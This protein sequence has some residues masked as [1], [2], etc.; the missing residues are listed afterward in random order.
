MWGI[1]ERPRASP[2]GYESSRGF[3]RAR[4]RSPKAKPEGEARRRSPKAKPE[5]EARRRSPKAKPEGKAPPK[6]RPILLTPLKRPTP[7]NTEN[8]A[9]RTPSGGGTARNTTDERR[10]G[11]ADCTSRASSSS[12][13][14]QSPAGESNPPKAPAPGTFQNRAEVPGGQTDTKRRR[15]TKSPV[16]GPNETQSPSTHRRP[17]KTQTKEGDRPPDQT[18]PPDPQRRPTDPPESALTSN[19]RSISGLEVDGAAE[20]GA[21]RR[22]RRRPRRQ[23]AVSATAR[24]CPLLQTRPHPPPRPRAAASTASSGSAHLQSASSWRIFRKFR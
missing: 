9:Q 15:E 10:E 11:T 21:L 6:S 7:T 23:P 20:F 14:S 5:G 16:S 1:R 3:G 17:E 22:L 19:C 4:R 18:R 2:M 8:S 13:R 24:A 12:S